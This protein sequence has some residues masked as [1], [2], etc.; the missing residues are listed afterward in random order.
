MKGKEAQEIIKMRMY[1]C[2]IIDE[3][4]SSELKKWRNTFSLINYRRISSCSEDCYNWDRN[5]SS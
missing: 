4:A 2:E 1:Y 3:E 5:S